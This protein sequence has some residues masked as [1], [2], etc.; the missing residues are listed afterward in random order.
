[1]KDLSHHLFELSLSLSKKLTNQIPK[2]DL[3]EIPNVESVKPFSSF[4]NPIKALQVP[5]AEFPGYKTVQRHGK[6]FGTGV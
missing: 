4:T 1:M 3:S 6:N 5:D 2:T